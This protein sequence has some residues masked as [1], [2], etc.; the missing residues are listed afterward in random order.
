MKETFL[1]KGTIYC[2]RTVTMIYVGRLVD[3]NESEFLVSDCSW[4]AETDRWQQFL[5]NGSVRENEPY[6]KAKNVVLSR[7][8]MLDIV[9][10]PKILDVQK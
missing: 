5:E 3:V 8:A 6:P 2:F 9:E 1:L 7:G 10:F 4:V